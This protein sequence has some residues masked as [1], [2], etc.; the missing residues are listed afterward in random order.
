MRRLRLV[1]LVVVLASAGS[2]LAN[3]ATPA[4]TPEDLVDIRGAYDTHIS[5]DGKRI[6]FVI[7]ELADPKKPQTP[8]GEHIWIVRADG[9]EPARSFVSSPKSENTPRWSPDGRSLAFLSNRGEDGQTQIWI[10]RADGGPAE[11][12]TSAPSGVDSYKW[13]PDGRMIAFLTRDDATDEE[14]KKQEALDDAIEVDHHYKYLRLWVIGL[15]DRKPAL[16]TPQNAEILDFDWSPDGASFAIASVAIPGF[17]RDLDCS[18]SVVRRS[19]GKLLRKLADDVSVLGPN[20]RWSPDG[21]T[22]LFHEASPGRGMHWVSLVDPG[23]AP[24]KPILKDYAATIWSCE[25]APDSQYAIA[26][27]LV[28]SR[29]KLVRIDTSTGEVKNLADKSIDSADFSVSADGRTIGFVTGEADSPPDV[30]SLTAAG[31][32][33]RLTTLNPQFASLSLGMLRDFSWKSRQTGQALQ[34]VLVTP[35][36]LKPGQPYPTIVEAHEGNSAWVFGWQGSWYQWAQLLASHGYVVFLPNVRGVT[37]QGWK[38]A[39]FMHTWSGAAFADTMDG[40][41]ALV[42]QK[43]A[44]PDRLGIGGWS[45]GGYMTTWAITHTNRFKAAVPFAAPTDFPIW[46]GAS[47]V[48]KLIELN[49]GGTPV[50]ARQQYEASSPYHFVEN[51]KTPTLILHGEA[52]G[53]VPIAQAYEFYHALKSLGV[54]TE[55]VVYPREGHWIQG[56]AHQIDFQRRVLGWF[57]KHLK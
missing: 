13:S 4:L 28:G 34:G 54:E 44:D 36:D 3:A 24:V 30:W 57:D 22:L 32:P 23:G 12:L 53:A 35:P 50:R 14:K 20:I 11:K 31:S 46:W 19:D 49:L 56:R 37:G 41:D 10:M 26:A 48:G 40:V 7:R 8:P 25:W 29:M 33:R 55:M 17:L 21:K 2:A 43:I 51:C 9:S 16:V 39:E 5:P 15:A 6:V 52:D 1:S 42:E 45:N 38:F 27:A 47:D 18:L